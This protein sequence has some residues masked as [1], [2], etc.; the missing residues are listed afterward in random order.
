MHS[1][2]KIQKSNQMLEGL[3]ALENEREKK[4]CSF[5]SAKKKKKTAGGH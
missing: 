1:T 4:H 2:L 3:M 5:I